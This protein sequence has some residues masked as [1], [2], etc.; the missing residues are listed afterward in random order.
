VFGPQESV[1]LA[2]Q[3]LTFSE[4]HDLWDG[5]QTKM[6]PSASYLARIV[7]LESGVDRVEYRDVQTRELVYGTAP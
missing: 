4:L 2:W 3:P 1:E 5:V 6:R 7:E